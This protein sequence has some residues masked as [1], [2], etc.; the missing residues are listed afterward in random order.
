M[1]FA[2]TNKSKNMMHSG[3]IKGI[4]NFYLT[5]QWLQ[6]PGGLPAALST[7]KFTI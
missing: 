1:S 4:K 7:G 5:G 3:K 2:L 6:P